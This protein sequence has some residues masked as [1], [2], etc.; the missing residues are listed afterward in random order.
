VTVKVFPFV[1]TIG[2]FGAL[3]PEGCEVHTTLCGAL[4]SWSLKVTVV[5]EATVSVDG[6]KLRD[7]S[8]PTPCGIA[9]VCA[10]P[11]GADDDDAEEVVVVIAVVLLVLALVVEL[12]VEDGGEL[13]V[14]VELDEVDAEETDEEAEA[15]VE[16]EVDETEALEVVDDDDMAYTA[17]SCVGDV[18]ETLRILS[19]EPVSAQ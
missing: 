11:D 16:P 3:A 9:M 2:E 1:M 12:V 19:V 8:E 18:M 15:L 17:T 7:V 13:L 4:V 14:V 5:P 6:E 10:P